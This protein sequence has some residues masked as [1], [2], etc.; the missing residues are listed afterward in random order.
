MNWIPF[1]FA[2]LQYIIEMT[3]KSILSK[4]EERQIVNNLKKFQAKLHK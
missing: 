4:L 3:N 2:D 1:A